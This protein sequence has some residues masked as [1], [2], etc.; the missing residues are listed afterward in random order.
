MRCPHCNAK[1]Y[2]NNPGTD[3]ILA[4]SMGHLCWK[5][6]KPLTTG[7]Q[8]KPYAQFPDLCVAELPDGETCNREAHN[9][10]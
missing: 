6:V 8:F 9:H 2:N 1:Q 3:P 7:H 4:K 10:D 5:C